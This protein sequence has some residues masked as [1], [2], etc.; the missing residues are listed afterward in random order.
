MSLIISRSIGIK[1]GSVPFYEPINFSS[2]NC[3][4]ISCTTSTTFFF[5]SKVSIE[6]LINFAST[7]P[8]YKL[9]ENYD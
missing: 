2:E 3:L 6:F 5:R 9:K 1:T 8:F 4:Q 7:N